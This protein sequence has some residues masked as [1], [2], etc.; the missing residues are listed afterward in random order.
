MAQAQ[1]SLR[2][3]ILRAF[4]GR[5]LLEGFEAQEMLGYKHSGFSVDTN[6]C[7]ATQDRA[8]LERLLNYC[9]RP[10]LALDRL[11]KAGSELI[12]YP[13]QPPNQPSPPSARDLARHLRLQH[14]GQRMADR[15]GAPHA[16][17]EPVALNLG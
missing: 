15:S 11:R 16:S 1:A 17:A 3:R 5:G 8:G 4:V 9:A 10:P 14:C 6:L 2:G 13:Q 12:S 7:M